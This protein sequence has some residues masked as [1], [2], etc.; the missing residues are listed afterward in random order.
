MKRINP[1]H[2]DIQSVLTS[3]IFD[4]IKGFEKWSNPGVVKLRNSL[5]EVLVKAAKMQIERDQKIARRAEKQAVKAAKAEAR[6]AVGRKAT[7]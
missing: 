3:G 5:E 6:K 1:S 2:S 7:A 4:A